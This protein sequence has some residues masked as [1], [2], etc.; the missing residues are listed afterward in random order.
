MLANR[1]R[2]A[3][4][5]IGMA[6]VVGLLTM[7]VA[8]A[9]AAAHYSV[10]SASTQDAGVPITVSGVIEGGQLGCIFLRTDW[11]SRFQLV[12]LESLPKPVPGTR[13]LVTGH[14]INGV[15][16][17]QAGRI[18]DVESIFPQA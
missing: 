7:A 4:T 3:A 8:S 5:M 17:C 2:Q 15:S 1:M 10:P 14:L 9:P 12:G 18:L 6:G 13:V 16:I 11:G